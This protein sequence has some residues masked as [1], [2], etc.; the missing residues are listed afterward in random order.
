[1]NNQKKI[2]LV[3]FGGIG[4]EI[5]FL[6][7]VKA[8]KTKFPEAKITLCLEP[9]SKSIKDLTSDIDD[10]ILTDIKSKNKYTELLKFY[11]KALFGGFDTVISSGSNKLIPVLLFFTGIKN[12]IGFNCGGFTAKLL[13]KAVTLNNQRFAGEM[14]FE[15]VKEFTDAEFE[16]PSISVAESSKSKDMILIHPGVSKMSIKKN[17][18]KSYGNE[19][20]AE[21]TEI[22]LNKGE[23][24]GLVG[25]PDDEDCI[26]YI[27]SKIDTNKYKNFHNFYGETKSLL[28]LASLMKPAKAV[29]CCDSAPM[30]L[31]AALNVKTVAMFGP[32]D[33][34]KLV[35]NKNNVFV[36]KNQICECRPCLWDKRSE[37]CDNKICLDISNEQI[38]NV[39]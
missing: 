23:Q 35:P 33:E 6:P 19:K 31:S 15:L 18:I 25:G 29:I 13:T 22:L 1:M 34:K 20:W 7:V 9:R 26:N 21:L 37:S 14:Y 27:L 24:V 30:H 38:I 12:R 8:V 3:N 36:I 32:T 28:D 11:F 10:V 2:L 4:D 5:L 16:N 39:L 17:I